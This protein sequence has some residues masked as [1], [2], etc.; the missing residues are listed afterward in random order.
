M[1]KTVKVFV[2]FLFFLSLFGALTWWFLVDTLR[3][4]FENGLKQIRQEHG[5][6]DIPQLLSRLS[7]VTVSDKE[8]TA[9]E[10]AEK[11]AVTVGQTDAAGT[12]PAE[13][14]DVSSP[15]EQLPAVEEEKPPP[16]P[17]EIPLSRVQN[18]IGRPADIT[19]KNGRVQSGEI[20]AVDALY[21]YIKVKI[22]G[23]SMAVKIAKRRINKIETKVEEEDYYPSF[24]E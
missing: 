16:K 24:Q 18:H 6:G 14:G 20:R 21:L 8:L 19:L 9:R 12:A 11:P 13:P 17:V 22:K 10:G 5:D 23:G 15:Q 1:K 2:I 4:N 7:R 3:L